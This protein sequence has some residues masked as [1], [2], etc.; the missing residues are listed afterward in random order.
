MVLAKDKNIFR[1]SSTKA[2]FLLTPFNPLRRGAIYVLTHPFF[3]LFI[4]LVIII[5]CVFMAIN[6]ENEV[7]E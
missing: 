5:N 4:M 7:V 1:F 6:E 3:S 2:V